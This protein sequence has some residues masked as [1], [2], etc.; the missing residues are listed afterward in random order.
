MIILTAV[1]AMV[2]GLVLACRGT[3]LGDALYGALV[4]KPADSLNR[5]PIALA[6][7]LVTVLM[8]AGFAVIAPELIPLA[9]AVDFALAVEL[10]AL[11]FVARASGWARV[12]RLYVL[13]QPKLLVSRLF[14]PASRSRQ[15]QPKRRRQSAAQ[16][17]PEARPLAFA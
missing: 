4:E 3:W 2:F 12:A 17:D 14:R 16:N 8:L 7:Y 1:F 10:A 6:A 13:K 15:H 11:V 9:A 5:G